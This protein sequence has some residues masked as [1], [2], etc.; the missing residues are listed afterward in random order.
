MD[1]TEARYILAKLIGNLSR[2]TYIDSCRESTNHFQ[3][4]AA[5]RRY[6]STLVNLSK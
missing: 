2:D 4:K 1:I 3:W 6:A 5:N